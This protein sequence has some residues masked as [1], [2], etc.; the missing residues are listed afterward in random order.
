MGS[1]CAQAGAID[2]AQKHFDKALESARNDPWSLAIVQR[3]LGE[4]QASLGQAQDSASTFADSVDDALSVEDVL[5]RAR[6]LASIASS[7]H[8]AVQNE[9]ARRTFVQAIAAAQ[10][11]EDDEA[12]AHTLT[13]I[14]KVQATAGFLAEAESTSQ[15]VSETMPWLK[16]Q[17]MIEIALAQAET[18]EFAENL[19]PL[20]AMSRSGQIEALSRMAVV[21]F[22]NGQADSAEQSIARAAELATVF[23]TSVHEDAAVGEFMNFSEAAEAMVQI[24]EARA[25]TGKPD[26]AVQI[27]LEIE[28]EKWRVKALS[29]IAG[30]LSKSGDTQE[31]RT[32]FERALNEQKQID[33]RW[34]KSAARSKQAETLQLI[35]KAQVGTRSFAVAMETA[36]KIPIA[37]V[38]V[39]A[40]A[41]IALEQAKA[42]QIEDART[43]FATALTVA[44][45]TNDR[46][47]PE[48]P[49][50]KPW[51]FERVT[52][53]PS[54]IPRADMLEC[55][56]TKEG[57]A[58]FLEEARL[59]LAE[60]IQSASE[61]RDKS[62]VQRLAALRR[63]G[64]AQLQMGDRGAALA[65]VERLDR[66]TELDASMHPNAGLLGNIAEAHAAEGHFTLALDLTNRIEDPW[67]KADTLATIAAKESGA[68][69]IDDARRHFS[70]SRDIAMALDEEARDQALEHLAVLQATC[71]DFAGALATADLVSD[72]PF[73]RP[74]VLQ[75]IATLQAEK[76]QF[77]GA[78]QTAERISKGEYWAATLRTLA[79]LEV[80]AGRPETA[81]HALDQLQEAANSSDDDEQRDKT[82]L[83]LG[84]L[85]A[86]MKDFGAALKVVT[87][88]SDEGIRAQ[89]E[90][91]IALAQ[92]K[93]TLVDDGLVTALR[94][95]VHRPRHLVEI[96]RS[97]TEMSDKE[98]FKQLLVPSA[99]FLDAAFE[100]C[101]LL[102]HLYPDQAS[103]IAEAVSWSV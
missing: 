16:D 81:R 76:G 28:D 64:R 13:D 84:T 6:L 77:T 70:E 51:R 65:M 92:I 11:T 54:L 57:Q 14:A 90:I 20:K 74:T 89:A 68:G 49:S 4:V 34:L 35:A 61:I 102:A 30:V 25:R 82:I 75:Q 48:R 91:T 26:L 96:A 31:T 85:H 62:N 39:E 42:G 53:F 101:G 21:Q 79:E 83:E 23:L 71:R 58:G 73:S 45:S 87:R 67:T 46:W 99:W 98:H 94:I 88:I 1:T 38:R 36:R 66:E 27:A 47:T 100:M 95:M 18:G 12:S 60:A 93:A 10:Q 56:A 5:R 50:G 55:I 59:T 3:W 44:R 86:K 15:M 103:R 69:R 32:I 80:L 8:D 43:T 63:I 22:G 37:E 33:G 29:R 9:A 41:N 52:M 40:I 97:L 2:D 72:D 24:A 78:W 7:Q 17:I 19:N